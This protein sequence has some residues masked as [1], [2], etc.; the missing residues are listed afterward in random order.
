MRVITMTLAVLFIVAGLVNESFALTTP[1]CRVCHTGGTGFANIA[2][3]HHQSVDCQRCHGVAFE[4]HYDCLVCHYPASTITG[5][6]DVTTSH[7]L[8]HDKTDVPDPGCSSC[9]LPDAFGEHSKYPFFADPGGELACDLCHQSSNLEVQIAIELGSG[10][11]GRATYCDDCHISMTGSSHEAAHDN[12]FVDSPGCLQCHA[13]NVVTEHVSR[14]WT[15]STCHAG[16]TQTLDP[17]VVQNAIANGS[18]PSNQPQYCSTC[19]GPDTGLHESV[20]DKT[21]LPADGFQ[22]CSVCHVA[23]VVTEHVTGQNLTCAVCHD[24]TRTDVI[25]AI[26]KGKTPSS[27]SVYCL[28]CHASQ[29][30]GHAPVAGNPWNQCLRCHTAIGFGQLVHTRHTAAAANDCSVCHAPAPNCTQCHDNNTVTPQI[31]I[32]GPGAEAHDRHTDPGQLNQDCSQCHISGAPGGTPIIE[33]YNQCDKCHTTQYGQLTHGAHI[34]ATGGD[35]NTCH[36]ATP[37]CTSCHDVAGPFTQTHDN[38]TGTY[39]VACNVCHVSGAPGSSPIIEPYNK[40]DTCHTTQY[41]QL[42]H[43]THITATNNDCNACHSPAPACTS[44]HDVSGPLTVTHDNHTNT[45]MVNCFAC[46]TSGAPGS[47]PIIEPYNQCDTCHSTQYGQLTHDTHITATNNDCNACHSPTPTCTSCHDIGGPMSVSHDAH[48]AR[49]I[50]C[51]SCHVSGVAGTEPIIEPFNT[52]DSCHTTQYDQL[53]HDTHITVTNNDCAACHTVQPTC[54]NCHTNQDFGHTVKEPYP[55]CGQCHSVDGP[56]KSLHDYHTSRR[57]ISCATCHGEQAPGCVS[58]H[59]DIHSEHIGSEV[60]DCTECHAQGVPGGEPIVE[61][62]N[63]C[64]SCHS[65]IQYGNSDHDR[66]ISQLNNNC[67]ACHGNANPT[68]G[69]CHKITGPGSTNHDYHANSRNISCSTCHTSGVP[70][71]GPIIEPYNQCAT[72]HSEIRYG[73]RVHNTHVSRNNN[74]AACHDNPN[75]NCLN[76]HFGSARSVHNEHDRYDCSRCH[77]SGVPEGAST[78]GWRH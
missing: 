43:D 6:K 62:F 31:N 26:N 69:E 51:S 10:P 24:S 9:H 78:S 34:T 58:C 53:T 65:S 17:V 75:P 41:G 21:F 14:G 18:T 72:C 74:C 13:D 44:C 64:A 77:V 71:V 7:A 76:C 40:C 3:R 30:K 29:G 37:T 52:C 45:Y 16:E 46:H 54:A 35:C 15:C 2:E 4:L 73:S 61:P 11:A 33:P 19:H 59:S 28:D 12:A 70:G 68:C 32:V 56:G 23:N 1:A 38:H 49:S 47:E 66:H 22:A 27:L 39:L 25:N 20:H 5:A 63:A 8:L 48:I 36:S 42:T 60:N 57:N 55:Q 50:N 67:S